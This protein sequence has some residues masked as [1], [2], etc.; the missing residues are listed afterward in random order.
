MSGATPL[1][2]AWS[3]KYLTCQFIGDRQYKQCTEWLTAYT[4]FMQKGVQV[5]CFE[6]E[7]LCLYTF[8]NIQVTRVP[9]IILTTLR[10]FPMVLLEFYIDL[11][12]RPHYGTLVDSASNKNEY[13]EYL[14]G[15][16]AAGA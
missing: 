2:M 3:R 10:Y 5:R 12:F 11:T 16:K 8:I 15:V 4:V 9:I 14:L 6:G 1:L 7:K 13:Q